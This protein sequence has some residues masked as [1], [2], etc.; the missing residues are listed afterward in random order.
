[1]LLDKLKNFPSKKTIVYFFWGRDMAGKPI[2][3]KTYEKNEFE[4]SRDFLKLK[5]K[6]PEYSIGFRWVL[7]AR[8]EYEF[9]VRVAKAAN[10]IKDNCSRTMSLLL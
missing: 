4:K 1:M 6:Y 3:A 5:F 9:D 10:M 2:K 8:I 7:R